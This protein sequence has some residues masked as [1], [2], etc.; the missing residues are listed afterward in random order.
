[1]AAIP[2][3]LAAV[4]LK[5]PMA[6]EAV[7]ATALLLWFLPLRYLCRPL[8]SPWWLGTVQIPQNANIIFLLRLSDVRFQLCVSFSDSDFE[9]SS[10]VQEIASA[11]VL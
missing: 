1:M 4:K 2:S 7:A 9:V 8:A 10:R 5:E 11:A 3:D 6:H